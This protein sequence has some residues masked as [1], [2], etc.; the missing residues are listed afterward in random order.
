MKRIIFLLLF[1]STLLSGQ[2]I[3]K[4]EVG[5]AEKNSRKAMFMSAVLPGTGQFYTR[6]VS[7]GIVYS[8]PELAG[9]SGAVYYQHSGNLKTDDYKSYADNHWDV[10]RWLDDYYGEYNEPWTNPAAEITHNVY[11]YVGTRRYTFTE[12]IQSFETWEEWQSFRNRIEL[13]KEYHF[14]ENISKYKQFKQGWDDWKDYK[15]D[16]YYQAIQ[17]SSPNQELYATLRKD[18]NDLLKRSTYFTSALMFNHLISAFD[19]YFRTTKWNK[20]FAHNV[21]INVVPNLY[22]QN[23]GLMIHMQIDLAGL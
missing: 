22:S 20:Q 18:A 1:L 10:I 12:F 15:D 9:I 19:A 6:S 4:I 7:W 16:P 3:E 13:E 8:A 5:Q 23:Q 21:H 11:I 14:Y 17:R 2:K